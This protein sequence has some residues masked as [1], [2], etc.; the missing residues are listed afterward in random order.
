MP[1][2]HA[3]QNDLAD[4]KAQLGIKHTCAIALLEHPDPDE[5]QLLIECLESQASITTYRGAVDYLAQVKNDPAHQ[6]LCE[7]CGWTRGMVCPECTPGCGCVTDCTGWRHQ[8]DG[9]AG[10]EVEDDSDT[11]WTCQ[12]CGHGEGTE[13]DEG[14]DCEDD[15]P[16]QE[17]GHTWNAPECVYR[18][19]CSQC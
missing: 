11:G 3:R 13:Y 7:K 15:G 8:Q 12:E 6:L 1:K 5:A 18:C 16:C 17:C 9:G 10:N 19:E 2:N 14:C 4:L